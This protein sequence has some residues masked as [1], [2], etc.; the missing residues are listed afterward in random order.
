MQLLII[1]EVFSHVLIRV[2][3][4]SIFMADYDYDCIV[5]LIYPGTVGCPYCMYYG[6]LTSFITTNS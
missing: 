3:A 6:L 1:E 4:C 5:F 2:I